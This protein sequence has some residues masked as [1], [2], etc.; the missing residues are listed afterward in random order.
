[1]KIM[2]VKW[3]KTSF[4]GV[5]Y[6]EHATRKHGIRPDR[7]YSIRYKI[8]GKDKEEVVGW[9]SEGIT[10]EIAFKRLSE[11]REN[12]RS[13]SGAKTL[14]EKRLL[15][16]AEEEAERQAKLRE[17]KQNITL[18]EYWEQSY[19]EHAQRTKKASSFRS[20]DGHMRVWILPLLGD[21]P[22][23]QIGFAEW[24][25]LVRSMSSKKL[26]QRTREYATGTLRRLMRHAQ[27]RGL[28]VQIPTSKQIGV[29]APKDN[30]RLRVLTPDEAEKL[31]TT[32]AKLDPATERLT[33]FCML[34]G[35][36][37]SEAVHLTWAHV[38]LIGQTVRFV[39]TK[40]KDTRIVYLS[41]ELIKMLKELPY[42]SLNEIV[43]PRR[44]GKP[45]IDKEDRSDT[46][47]YFSEAVKIL[48][49]N[50]GRGRRD[51]V[52]FHTIRHTVATNLAK[53]LDVRSLMDVMGWKV[54]EMA[55]RY[56][57]TQE[58]TKRHAAN[59]LSESW[60]KIDNTKILPFKL[61]L[62]SEQ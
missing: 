25:A 54:I 56:I 44:D 24:D 50:E 17:E 26:S 46:P 43:F 14:E 18:R 2:A 8:D 40:N 23:V 3:F 6:R 61:A 35:C 45:F 62:K 19:K 29:Q 33:R 36:R 15:A 21:L 37:L 60:K 47:Y 32:L 55:A 9:S 10:Q 48:G 34:T 38:D 11:L 4:L 57:H 41:Q 39:D 51:R 31:L 7:C 13:G 16:K 28:P 49:F 58:E 42:A 52:T 59:A 20:E 30:R 1:M 12:L 5:R 27:D 22:L 53:I